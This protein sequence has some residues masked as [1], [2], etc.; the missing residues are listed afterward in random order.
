MVAALQRVLEPR[1]GHS[2]LR[3]LVAVCPLAFPNGG[4]VDLTDLMGGNTLADN[5]TVTTA[6]GPSRKLA[7]A[8]Q[9]TALTEEYLSAADNAALSVADID[10]CISLWS[11]RDSAPATDMLLASKDNAVAN[12]R[13]WGIYW[14]TATARFGFYI[15]N[16]TGATI[17]NMTAS[18]F[19]AT[20]TATWYHLACWH[21]SVAN[22][23]NM[24][25]N[26]GTITSVATTI[27]PANT[28]AGF[29]IGARGSTPALFWNGRV[30]NVA[31]WKRIPGPKERTWLYNGGQGRQF[32]KNR[33]FY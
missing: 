32:R 15:F 3:R 13:E 12:E 11:Y 30:C 9:F 1:A 6:A 20:T 7:R 2:L 19:G 16:S 31:F 25:V 4:V 5:N 14:D 28:I 33:G 18:A 27:V 17:D 8:T 23:I 21:D 29:K 22:T 24:Q 10:F 26:N